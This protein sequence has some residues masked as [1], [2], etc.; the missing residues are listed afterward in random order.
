MAGIKKNQ[1]AEEAYKEI[2][3][4]II[5]NVSAMFLRKTLDYDSG[6]AFQFLGVK[7]QFGDINRK[8]WKLY[9]ALWM[10]E[11]LVGE[12]P[13]EILH[14]F[15]GHCL[16]TIW[17]LQKEASEK[18]IQEKE[19]QEAELLANRS[20]LEEEEERYREDKARALR[21]DPE[22]QRLLE[23]EE[24]IE[25]RHT[26]QQRLRTPVEQRAWDQ[27]YGRPQFADHLKQAGESYDC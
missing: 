23:E 17:L 11:P 3:E 10:D 19:D 20:R 14:D 6:P 21:E 1:T 22:F 27:N 7:G 5:P 26:L 16:L 4:V 18:A 15:I 12:Q 24:E 8:F 13:I 9:K 2:I 25:R